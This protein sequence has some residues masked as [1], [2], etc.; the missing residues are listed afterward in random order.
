M[1]V[2]V[3]EAASAYSSSCMDALI[4]SD[5]LVMDLLIAC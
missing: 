4:W 3:R 1:R 5:T 2:T